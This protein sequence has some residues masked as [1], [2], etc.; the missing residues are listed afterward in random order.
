METTSVHPDIDQL[1]NFQPLQALDQERLVE[2]ASTIH[3][4]SMDAGTTVFKRSNNDDY[5]L[6]LLEGELELTAADGKKNHIQ[7]V[8]LQPPIQ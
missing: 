7:P 3:I 1:L 2:L 5:T 6:L 4:E 8:T